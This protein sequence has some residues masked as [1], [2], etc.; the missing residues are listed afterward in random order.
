MIE[1]LST[2]DKGL[3]EGMSAPSDTAPPLPSRCGV[4][5]SLG[6]HGN[7]SLFS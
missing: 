5:R 2:R 7:S 6:A 1:K 3:E 4:E